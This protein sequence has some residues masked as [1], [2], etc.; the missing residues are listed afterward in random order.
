MLSQVSPAFRLSKEI[1]IQRGFNED[2]PGGSQDVVVNM[3]S[4]DDVQ[5][6]IERSVVVDGTLESVESFERRIGGTPRYTWNQGYAK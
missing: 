2:G 3:Q 1:K 5:M 6:R 4:G